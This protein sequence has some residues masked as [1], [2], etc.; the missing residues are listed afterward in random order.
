MIHSIEDYTKCY[1]ITFCFNYDI[2][3]LKIQTFVVAFAITVVFKFFTLN[4]TISPLPSF[5][6]ISSPEF[7]NISRMQLRI[8]F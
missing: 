5:I 3:Y 6:N 8:A 1:T 7:R 2:K 4:S